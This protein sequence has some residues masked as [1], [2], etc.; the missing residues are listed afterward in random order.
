MLKT[1]LT[2]VGMAQGPLIM[3]VQNRQDERDRDAVRG[4]HEKL[5]RLSSK[6]K[7]APGV[8]SRWKI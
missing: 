3:M 4:T 6:S 8:K 1:A 7:K 2:I 5:D